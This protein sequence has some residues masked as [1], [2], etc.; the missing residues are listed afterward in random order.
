MLLKELFKTITDDGDGDDDNYTV[1]GVCR[2][3]PHFAIWAKM[4]ARRFW[5]K[6]I[7]RI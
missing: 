7:P 6:Q 2:R 5:A 4:S 3:H 1:T